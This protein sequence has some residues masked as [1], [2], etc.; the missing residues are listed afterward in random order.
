MQPISDLSQTVDKSRMRKF[1]QQLD[2]P[3][4]YDLSTE[5]IA[6]RMDE[7]D[8]NKNGLIDVASTLKLAVK[9]NEMVRPRDITNL[10]ALFEA[11]NCRFMSY[12]AMS[13]RLETVKSCFSDP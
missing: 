6:K 11:E 10:F 12:N 9:I 2:V 13:S 4:H 1:L 8:H 7:A 5:T 3:S